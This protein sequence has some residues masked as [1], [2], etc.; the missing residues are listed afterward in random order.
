[1]HLVEAVWEWGEYQREVDNFTNK[2]IG[3]WHTDPEDSNSLR[4]YGDVTLNFTEDGRLIYTIHGEVKDE[5]MLLSYR[6]ENQTVVTDQPSKPREERTAFSLTPEGKLTLFYEG[7]QS[8][9][10]CES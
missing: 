3:R 9:Y 7:Y 4:D 5:I 1:M 8:Q 10:V 2:M 6:V